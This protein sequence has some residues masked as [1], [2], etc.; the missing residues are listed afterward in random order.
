MTPE[1]AKKIIENLTYEQKVALNEL[2]KDLQR[3][4]E[5]SESLPA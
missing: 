4:R 2:L 1:Q 5:L 3:K